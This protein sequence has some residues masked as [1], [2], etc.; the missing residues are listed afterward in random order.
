MRYELED[1]QKVLQLQLPD[2]NDKDSRPNLLFKERKV[3]AGENFVA[4][5]PDGWH[6]ITLEL[7]MR[8]EGVHSW[9]ISTPGFEDICP[10]GLFVKE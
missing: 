5:F 7:D 9:Y 10:V 4:L 2:P 8:K 1:E 3:F 6:E